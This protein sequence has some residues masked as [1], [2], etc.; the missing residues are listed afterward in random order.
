LAKTEEEIKMNVMKQV[1][2]NDPV[3]ICE[4]AFW[5]YDEGDYK[6]AFE[7]WTKSAELGDIDAH[8]QLS[9]LYRDGQGVEKDKKK[10]FHHLEQ[11]VIGGN[12]GARHYLGC[13]EWENGRLDRAVKHFIIAANLGDD[14]ALQS[15]K[16]GFQRGYVS[17]EDFAA[18]LRAHQAAVD[19]TKSSQRDKAEA[20]LQNLM[21]ARAGR[22]SYVG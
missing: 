3:A 1:E 14:G 9:C 18:A 6:G 15:L 17:K 20:L 16:D 8:Y 4:V 10:Q 7:Y 13:E 5:S 12:A 19:A 2:V 11:A 22:Q 21:A